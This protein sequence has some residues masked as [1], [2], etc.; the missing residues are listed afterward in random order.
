MNPKCS[1]ALKSMGDAYPCLP[2]LPHQYRP[3]PPHMP[4]WGCRPSAP[5]TMTTVSALGRTTC[6]RQTTVSTGTLHGCPTGR[7]WYIMCFSFHLFPDNNVAMLPGLHC[8]NAKGNEYSADIRSAKI[9]SHLTGSHCLEAT[10]SSPSWPLLLSCGAMP[11][12]FC[13]WFPSTSRKLFM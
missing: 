10:R 6:R 2:Y 5:A 3:I 8:R 13:I 12:E 4:I 9:P 7:D 1:M 11:K